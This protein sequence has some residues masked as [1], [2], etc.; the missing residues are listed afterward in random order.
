M[1]KLPVRISETETPELPKRTVRRRKMNRSHP[2]GNRSASSLYVFNIY[3]I[4]EWERCPI[5]TTA[6]RF[7]IIYSPLI[8]LISKLKKRSRQAR[9][10]TPETG[11]KV[12]GEAC[13][14]RSF[15]I[16]SYCL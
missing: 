13:P 8:E 11:V 3:G 5:P 9:P 15:E 1:L 14:S 12:E 16:T 4:H 7:R 10:S 2:C 6:Q